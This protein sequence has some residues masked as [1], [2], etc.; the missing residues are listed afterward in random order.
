MIDMLNN[1][2]ACLERG[3]EIYMNTLLRMTGKIAACL[4]LLLHSPEHETVRQVANW[5]K[6]PADILT[7]ILTPLAVAA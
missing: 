6:L 7:D 5:Q 1:V 3:T 2:P 4:D